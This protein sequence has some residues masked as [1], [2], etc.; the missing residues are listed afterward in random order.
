MNLINVINWYEQQNLDLFDGILIPNELDKD[1]LIDTIL[2]FSATAI[3]LYTDYDLFNMKNKI[4][5]K[6]NYDNISKL[7]SAFAEEYNPIHNYDRYEERDETRNIDESYSRDNDGT[8]SSNETRSDTDELQVSAFDSSAYQ[9]KQ[10]DTN[11]GT[12]GLTGS[13]TE[14][15]SGTSSHEDKYITDNHLYGNIGVTTTQQMLESEIDLRERW[16]IYEWIARKWYNEFMLKVE[17]PSFGW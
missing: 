15:E 12:T 9:P 7:I 3:P 8:S 17:D 11:T 10:K 13:T 14:D 2:D 1:T 6:R 16:N 5:F 4:F